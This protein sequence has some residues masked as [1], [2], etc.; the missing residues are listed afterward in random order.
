MK[1]VPENISRGI[2]RA[3]LKSK[4]NSPHIFFAAG[5]VG[6][7]GSTVLACRATLKLE[8]AFDE[9]EQDFHQ[10]KTMGIES[11]QT[12]TEYA[13]REYYRDMGYVYSRT[14]VRFGILY[15]PAIV[16]GG[17][18]IAALTGSHIQLN[19]RNKALTSTLATV[20]SLF[21]EYRGRVRK[22]LGE[23]RELEIYHDVQEETITEDGRKKV[24][25]VVKGTGFSPYA[26]FFDETC[27]NWKKDAELNR[28]FLQCQ[29]NYANH[30]LR[31]RGHV[32]LNDVYDMLGLERSSAGAVCGWVYEGDGDGYID[33]GL[34]GPESHRFINGLERSILLDFNVDGVIYQKIDKANK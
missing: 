27:V 10:V 25:K 11:K 31:V 34:F 1:Y 26:R 22:E 7:V 29:E 24:V 23:E 32:M 30:M 4:K 21:N 16:L 13:K 8:K 12:G 33:F 19:N 2:G 6:I 28:F 5:L 14:I 18:S 9:I 3:V 15:G 17:A 20:T